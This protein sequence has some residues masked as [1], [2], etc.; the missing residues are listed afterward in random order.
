MHQFLRTQQLQ[1]RQHRLKCCHL[2]GMRVIEIDR[3]PE[4]ESGGTLYEKVE[5]TQQTSRTEMQIPTY[6]YTVDIGDN[7]VCLAV[8]RLDTQSTRMLCAVYQPCVGASQVF[9]KSTVEVAG[10]RTELK[11]EFLKEMGHKRNETILER[12]NPLGSSLFQT[13]NCVPSSWLVI[14]CK[15]GLTCRLRAFLRN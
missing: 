8:I 14:K 6:W 7:S 15:K 1:T 2:V 10:T 3:A 12:V 9:K 13:L 11:I 4:N 5:R